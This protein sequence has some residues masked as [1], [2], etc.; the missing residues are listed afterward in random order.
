MRKNAIL[1]IGLAVMMLAMIPLMA[2]Q[3][4]LAADVP[5]AP[6]V[7]S[8]KIVEN[9]E[10]YYKITDLEFVGGATSRASNWIHPSP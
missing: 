8:D 2:S 4:I 10:L 6:V 9:M 7:F 1:G 5:V 3:M